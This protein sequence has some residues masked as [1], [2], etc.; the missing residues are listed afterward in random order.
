MAIAS[1]LAQSRE[2][3]FGYERWRFLVARRSEPEQSGAQFRNAR[4]SGGRLS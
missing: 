4:E 2:G 3:L 1:S